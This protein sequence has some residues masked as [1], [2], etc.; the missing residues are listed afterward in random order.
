MR[1]VASGLWY[2]EGPLALRD[3]SVLVVEIARET[4]TRIYPDGRTEIVARIPGG[5]NGSALGPDGRVYVCNNGGLAFV[6]D[7]P[8]FRSLGQSRDYVGG[9]ID[10]VDLSTGAVEQIYESCDGNR[11]KGP[12]D[13][14]FDEAGGF[15]FTD[16]GKRRDRDF[17]RGFVYWAKADGSEIREVIPR[18][19]QPNGIGLSP[20]DRTLYVAETH[21]AR[22]WAFE[23]EAP[24]KLRLAPSR[25]PYGGRLVAGPG[26]YLQFD[27]L[28]VARSGNI[29]VAMPEGCSVA[30]FSPDGTLDRR[31]PV[32]DLH[33]TNICFGGP[34]MRTAYVTLGHRGELIEMDWH[35]PGLVLHHQDG[36]SRV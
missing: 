2:P 22:L 27:S 14:V 33:P 36:V 28:A 19:F 7:G 18:L 23:V 32:P 15:W 11:L 4:L 26:G 29:C 3:G 34:D 31:H 9:S 5:P 12:N 6:R 16:F 13:I 17:D 25:S 24:G 35:E 30:E 10:A 1:V 8:G 20:D 21:S